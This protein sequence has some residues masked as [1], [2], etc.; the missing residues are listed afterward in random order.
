MDEPW[1]DQR[2][3][4]LSGRSGTEGGLNVPKSARGRSSLQSVVRLGDPGPSVPEPR[5][6]AARSSGVLDAVLWFS[7]GATYHTD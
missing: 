6:N 4:G 2:G 3:A 1:S 7:Q 5:Q